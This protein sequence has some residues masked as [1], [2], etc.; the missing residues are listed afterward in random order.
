MWDRRRARC[1]SNH[2][3]GHG[4]DLKRADVKGT[5]VTRAQVKPT[6]V[7]Q[8]DAKGTDVKG[9][10]VNSVKEKEAHVDVPHYHPRPPGRRPLTLAMVLWDGYRLRC[11]CAYSL[12][13]VLMVG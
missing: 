10:G 13:Q 12:F 7:K 3:L 5:D 1:S 2:L 8:T 9:T 4:A 6:D 11:C